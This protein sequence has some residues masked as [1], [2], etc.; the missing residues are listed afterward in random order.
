VTIKSEL[1]FKF[2]YE[3]CRL[4]KQNINYSLIHVY[5]DRLLCVYY[6]VVG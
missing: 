3:F 2:N 5:L 6:Y 1:K 4:G